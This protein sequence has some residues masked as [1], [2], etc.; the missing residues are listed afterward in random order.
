VPAQ[1]TDD[2][3][4]DAFSDMLRQ[5]ILL[6]EVLHEKAVL[7]V[8]ALPRRRRE[9]VDI[10]VLKRVV[11]VYLRGILSCLFLSSSPAASFGELIV[12]T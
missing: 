4:E 5:A 11:G 1:L 12:D 8:A 2:V 7:L 3:V 10:M 6:A 9:A